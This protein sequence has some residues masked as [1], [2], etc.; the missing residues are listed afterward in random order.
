MRVAKQKG[1]YAYTDEMM[2]KS[3]KLKAGSRITLSKWVGRGSEAHMQRIQ[4]KLLGIYPYYI[5]LDIK[6][7][8][9]RYRECFLIK[10][11]FLGNIKVQIGG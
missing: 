11:I 10:D 9:G 1:R 3:L 4:G 2:R 5:L 8:K 7:K 6:G